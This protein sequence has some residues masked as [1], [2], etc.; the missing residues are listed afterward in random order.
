[1]EKLAKLRTAIEA[2]FKAIRVL[3]PGYSIAAVTFEKQIDYNKNNEYNYVEIAGKGS[4]LD[5]AVDDWEKASKEL[6]PEGG[7]VVDLAC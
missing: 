1:M 5:E 3:E 2:K 6:I 7:G 4:S